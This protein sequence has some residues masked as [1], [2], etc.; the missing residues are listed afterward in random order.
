[1]RDL[2]GAPVFYQDV[3]RLD[4]CGEDTDLL[5]DLEQAVI[6]QLS[7]TNVEFDDLFVFSATAAPGTPDGYDLTIE[8]FHRSITYTVTYWR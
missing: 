3:F 4:L 1:M 8:T 2:T 7:K 5:F 6:K